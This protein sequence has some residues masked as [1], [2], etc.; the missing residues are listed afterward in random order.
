[1]KTYFR[2]PRTRSRKG[3]SQAELLGAFP[4]LLSLTTN[5]EVPVLKRIEVGSDPTDRRECG[6]IV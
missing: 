4:E 2:G 5:P 3:L 1:M 6:G